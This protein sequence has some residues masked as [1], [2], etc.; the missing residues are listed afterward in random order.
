MLAALTAGSTAC[1]RENQVETAS[2]DLLSLDADMAL[3]G[4]EHYMTRD[5]LRRAHLLADTAY[6]LQD[7]SKVRLRPVNVTFFDGEGHEVSELTAR[8]GLYN[9]RTNDMEVRGEVVVLSRRD[10]QRLET[11]RLTYSA[12]EDQLRSDTSFVLYQGNTVLRG[13]GLVSD[14]DL[15]KARVTQPSAV[16]ENPRAPGPGS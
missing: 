13:T 15:R 6:F 11:A 5:G 9:M 1:R 4:M 3:L 16:V 10:F 8:E 14:P 7:S 2:P 12:R